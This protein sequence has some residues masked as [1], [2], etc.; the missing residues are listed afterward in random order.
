MSPERLSFSATAPALRSGVVRIVRR[1][2]HPVGFVL[3]NVWLV[4]H[5]AAIILAPWSVPPA[6]RL[7]QNS[8]RAVGAYDQLLFLN[9]GYH[10]FAPEP[11]NSTLVAYVLEMPDGSLQTGRIPNADIRPRLFY[12]RHFMLTE[13]LASDDLSPQLHTELVRSMARELCRQHQARRVTLSRVTHRLPT[14]EFVRAGGA[15]D[16][17]ESYTEEPLGTFSSDDL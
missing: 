5:L 10:Y 11:G 4:Y 14:M 9:H 2:G 17:P 6:S 8:W 16:D 12:H 3:V 13:Y 1:W 7:V 15:L